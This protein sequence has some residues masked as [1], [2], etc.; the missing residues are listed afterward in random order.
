[1][2]ASSM[3]ALVL[4]VVTADFADTS[5]SVLFVT[6]PILVRMCT[7]LHSGCPLCS[8]ASTLLQP[9]GGTTTLTSLPP[10]MRHPASDDNSRC[11]GQYVWFD[12]LIRLVWPSLHNIVKDSC[13]QRTLP[14]PGSNLCWGDT[15]LLQL[16]NHQYKCS[17]SGASWN[18]IMHQ[19]LHALLYSSRIRG[20]VSGNPHIH[21]PAHLEPKTPKLT[22][23]S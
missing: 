22:L 20:G 8:S 19:H 13:H 9:C 7:G 3:A 2:S 15:G 11:L 10:M 4:V 17:G 23:S 6:T 21:P 1:M 12:V 14:G 18:F 16:F 5:N